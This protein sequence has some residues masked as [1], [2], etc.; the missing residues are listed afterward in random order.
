MK[1]QQKKKKKKGTPRRENGAGI[2]DR[3]L[4]G[5]RQVYLTPTTPL[6]MVSKS[7]VLHVRVLP[8]RTECAPSSTAHLHMGAVVQQIQVRGERTGVWLRGKAAPPPGLHIHG[9]GVD[10]TPGPQEGTVAKDAPD[11]LGKQRLQ[12]REK[13]SGGR[14]ELSHT[15][16][17]LFGLCSQGFGKKIHHFW[18]QANGAG[19][20][21]W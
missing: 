1:T 3:K 11:G 20:G 14:K 6:S 19:V 10:R 16:S 4:A 21:L 17:L 13:A 15:G 7:Q 2:K 12:G 9:P 5:G 8:V 18:L